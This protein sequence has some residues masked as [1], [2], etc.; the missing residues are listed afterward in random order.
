M[1]QK[2]KKKKSSKAPLFTILAA[3][4]VAGGITT[5]A[6]LHHTPKTPT[7]AS[8][9]SNQ[10]ATIKLTTNSSDSS[11]PPSSNPDI[12]TPTPVTNVP[13]A[14]TPPASSNGPTA[15]SGTFVSDYSA[16]M[17]TQEDSS[18]N[19]TVG[20]TCT[21]TFKNVANGSTVSLSPMVA[22]TSKDAQESSAIWSS[23]T[24]S[25]IGLSQGTWQVSATAT[26]NGGS[27][28]TTSQV[29]LD[30]S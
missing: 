24:P 5:V 12:P 27:Q 9:T 10:S 4:V 28:T 29:T 8:K 2:R 13:G 1:S 15:P 21:I 6:L 3:I 7:T 30:I 20:A 16:T 17:S 25:S 19:T 22:G 26:L 18:C 11:A 14:T 23:W